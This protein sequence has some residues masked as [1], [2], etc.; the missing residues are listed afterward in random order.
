MKFFKQILSRAA[1]Q[2]VGVGVWKI[3]VFAAALADLPRQQDKCNHKVCATLLFAFFAIRR[4]HHYLSQFVSVFSRS[5][6]LCWFFTHFRRVCIWPECIF[7]PNAWRSPHSTQ[8]A[9]KRR[10]MILRELWRYYRTLFALAN[11]DAQYSLFEC[12]LRFRIGIG[13]GIR[14]VAAV[15]MK[16][17]LLLIMTRRSSLAERWWNWYFNWEP[18]IRK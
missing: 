7:D 1:R 13:Y 11:G 16:C 10:V 14:F 3:V 4:R 2:S 6:P 17:N 5:H 12:G 18:L 15:L 8:N 9:L